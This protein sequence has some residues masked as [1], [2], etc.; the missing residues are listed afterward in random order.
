FSELNRAVEGIT[1]RQAAYSPGAYDDRIVEIDGEL[2]TARRALAKIDTEL[3]T[4]REE[5]THP[6]SLANGAY[7][8]TASVIAEQVA[9]ERERL[10]W[11]RPPREPP[12]DPPVT[13]ADLASWLRV[14]RSYDDNAITHSQL[15][16]LASEHL[17]TPAEFGNAVTTEREAKADVERLAA[18][19]RHA[20]YGSI[21]ALG[22]DARTQLGKALR[23]LEERRRK[24]NRHG[25]DWLNDALTAA[26]SGRSAGWQ[27]LLQRSQELM[28]QIEQLLASLGASAISIIVAKK[29]KTVRADAAAAMQH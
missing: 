3:R 22:A 14:R 15:Q 17:P 24:L 12:D 19:Q 5:E 23:D 27:A 28:D 13:A 4:L 10:G 6:Q 25:Y 9:S 20:A 26:L 2:D 11:L 29:K 1:T 7:R 21:L 8:G 18:L 16:I